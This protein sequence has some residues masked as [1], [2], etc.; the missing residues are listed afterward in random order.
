MPTEHTG[1]S[2]IRATDANRADV[3]SALDAALD[4]GQLD[5][6]EHLERVR[7]AA[8]ARWVR[9]LRPLLADL[10]GVEV[11]LPGDR[12]RKTGG[13]RAS[14]SPSDATPTDQGRRSRLV[15]RALIAVPV[16]ALGLVAVVALTGNEGPS[17]ADTS[18][19]AVEQVDD[20]AGGA[21]G[22]AEALVL[23]NP[24]P[25][26]LNGLQRVFST[27]P[28]A[29]GSEIATRITAHPEHAGMEW[30]DPEHPSRTFRST[31]RGG[32]SEPD[33]RP[34]TGD[35]SFR[36]ADLD[37]EMIAAII[38]GAPATL[39]IPDGAPSHIIVEPDSSGM[40]VYSVYA[41]NEVHQS[42]Y[43]QVNH[44]GEPV[45]VHPAN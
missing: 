39:G 5:R 25:L 4:S 13:A 7:A 23:G 38:A 21:Y 2:G 28:G 19:A 10:Q 37:A 9:E 15:T 44:A 17:P 26:T 42:G 27:A 35:G 41:S 6:F 43:L 22:A 31:Y 18:P 34:T 29:S 30:V 12:K 24:S 8:R 40:P 33:D 14:S 20:G 36:F 16:V 1:D 11:E 45:R 3:S 32:W